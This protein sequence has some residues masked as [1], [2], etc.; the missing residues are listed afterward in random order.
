MAQERQSQRA[1]HRH[2]GDARSQRLHPDGHGLVDRA[3]RA[4]ATGLPHYPGPPNRRAQRHRHLREGSRAAGPKGWLM[5]PASTSTGRPSSSGSWTWCLPE[6]SPST[7]PLRRRLCHGPARNRPPPWRPRSGRHDPGPAGRHRAAR[8]ERHPDRP[9]AGDLEH[10]GYSVRPANAALGTFDQHT[11][12][13]VKH[14]QLHFFSGTRESL[15][16]AQ[17]GRVDA[18][19]AGWIRAVR[20]SVP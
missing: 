1:V 13:A 6:P 8:P 2:R 11:E 9:A 14:F 18:T 20:P 4:A 19:T 7:T 17:L 3:D 15:R 10:I 12:K 5:T 16:R